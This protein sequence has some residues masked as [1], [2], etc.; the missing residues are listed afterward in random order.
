M[1]GAGVVRECLREAHRQQR[2]RSQVD[3]GVDGQEVRGCL[4]RGRRGGIRIRPQLRT[5]EPHVH[6]LRRESCG[7]CMEVLL[8]RHGGR[9]RKRQKQNITLSSQRSYCELQ[10][11]H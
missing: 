1:P 4:A 5:Q 8:A 6:V 3:Q 2:E 10:Q 11:T 9:E 7:V